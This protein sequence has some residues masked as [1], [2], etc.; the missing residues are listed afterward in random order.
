M[1]REKNNSSSDS[2]ENNFSKNFDN[3]VNK[4]LKN[5][6]NQL[7]K[8]SNRI[9]SAGIQSYKP[10]QPILSKKLYIFF[11]IYTSY[12]ENQHNFFFF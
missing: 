1:D 6:L 3:K 4:I 2:R 9:L 12:K 10:I 5:D 7:E 11:K 8:V